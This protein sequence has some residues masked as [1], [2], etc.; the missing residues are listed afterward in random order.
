VSGAA[1]FAQA[2]GEVDAG[3]P[4]GVRSAWSGGGAHFLT[5]VGYDV[6]LQMLAV[7]DPLFGKSDVDYSTFCT[8]YHDAGT[9]TN[10]YYIKL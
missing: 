1:T 8:D 2:Q 4:L 10:S 6:P 7:D 5:I 3:R 9:W